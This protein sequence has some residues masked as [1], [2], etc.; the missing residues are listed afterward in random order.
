MSKHRI[1][2]HDDLKAEMMAVARGDQPASKDAAVASFNSV[3]AVSRLLTSEN[4][5]LLA[6]IRDFQP[7]SIGELARL[8]NRAESNLT[9]T[10]DKL[11]A[12]GL[13]SFETT[14]RRKKPLV[15]VGRIVVEIDPFTDNDRLEMH[16]MPLTPA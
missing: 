15:N 11:S 13:L 1:M 6:L 3:E 12:M 4:R 9:R 14:G 5:K 8:A 16:A 7:D 10:L 2:S